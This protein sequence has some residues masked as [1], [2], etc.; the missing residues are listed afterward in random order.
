MNTNSDI[1]KFTQAINKA[2]K[3]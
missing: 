2:R 1:Y 3:E